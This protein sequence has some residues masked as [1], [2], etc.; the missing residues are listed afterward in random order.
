MEMTGKPR[1]SN[2]ERVAATRGALLDAAA[3]LFGRLGYEGTSTTAVLEATGLARGALYHHFED[4]RALFVAVADRAERALV[5]EIEAATASI[6]DARQRLRAG[7][8]LY[9]DSVSRPDRARI[10]LRDAP[11]VLGPERWR[12]LA[13]A[14]WTRQLGGLIGGLHGTSGKSGRGAPA[15]PLLIGAAIDRAALALADGGSDPA[16][17]KAAVGLLLDRVLA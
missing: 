8:L 5:A 1:R 7:V 4:K 11:A 14:A 12:E 9:L 16:A 6:A 13:D 17:I 2:A 10:L 15:L 3:E